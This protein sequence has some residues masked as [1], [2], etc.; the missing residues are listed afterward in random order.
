MKW[1]IALVGYMFYRFPGAL[2][3]FFLGSLLE[4]VSIQSQTFRPPGRSLDKGSFELKLLSLAAVVIKADGAIRDEELRYVR[5]YFIGQYGADRAQEI[6]QIFNREIKKETQS[7]QD[8]A[9]VFARGTVYATRLQILHFLFGIANADGQVSPSE[10]DKLKQIA[11]ALRLRFQ[12]FDSIKAMFIKETDQ[13]YKILELSPDASD[14]QIKKAYRE[15]VK[16]YH[17]D[18]IKTQDEALRKGAQQ[19][20]IQIQ[21][22]YEALKKKRGF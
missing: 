13:A 9:A 2:L 8:V 18:R 4:Q 17:P 11:T 16:K 15:K 1:I 14:N 3:G 21:E 19:K 5:N 7:V 22:A 12:D 6:F 10:L 20:F